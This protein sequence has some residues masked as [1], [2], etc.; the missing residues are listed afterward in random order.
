VPQAPKVSRPAAPS[1]PARGDRTIAAS[2]AKDPRLEARVKA[3]LPAGMTLEQA[4]EGFR[5]QGQFIAA[6]QASKNLDINF[7]DLKAEMTGDPPLTLGQAIEKLKPS[8]ARAR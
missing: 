4:S 3:M 8:A 6:L 5:N 7:A 2:I 1:P